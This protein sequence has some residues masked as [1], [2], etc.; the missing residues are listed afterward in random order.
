MES[1][2]NPETRSG[3]AYITVKK[4]KRVTHRD[5]E[6]SE[7]LVRESFDIEWSNSMWAHRESI[8]YDQRP[9]AYGW[10]DPAAKKA[11]MATRYSGYDPIRREY[12]HIE[13]DLARKFTP[14]SRRE[15]SKRQNYWCSMRYYLADDGVC[16]DDDPIKRRYN[17]ERRPSYLSR[18]PRPVIDL[19]IN[20][21]STRAR[22]DMWELYFELP[23]KSPT[24]AARDKCYRC[25]GLGHWA[26]DCDQ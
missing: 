14:G 10:R 21:V 17:D 7:S 26:E 25:G 20:F 3:I 4:R 1:I 22:L 16:D 24:P 12:H 8:P 11:F 18:L 5:N 19:L 6:F 9:K 23:R 13:V 15:W 2:N